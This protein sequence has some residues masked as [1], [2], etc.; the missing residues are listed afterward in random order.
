MT[1]WAHINLNAFLESRKIQG[2]TLDMLQMK[3][4]TGL[5]ALLI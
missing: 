3:I 1:M 2:Y 5:A 4:G